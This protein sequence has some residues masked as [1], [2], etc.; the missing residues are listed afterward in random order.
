MGNR[1]QSVLSTRAM[2]VSV[3]V[4]FATGCD[5]SRPLYEYEYETT[6][7]KDLPTGAG[8]LAKAPIVFTLHL[9]NKENTLLIRSKTVD[10]TGKTDFGNETLSCS[11]FDHGNFTCERP[12]G[13]EKLLMTEGKLTSYFDG[14]QRVWTRHTF[15]LGHKVS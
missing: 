13:R 6:Y 7:T 1:T 5:S 8:G 2:L 11:V 4:L 15:I 12:D 10:A 14:E 3:T 9:E